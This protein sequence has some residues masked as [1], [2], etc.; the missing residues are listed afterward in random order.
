MTVP[1]KSKMLGWSCVRC[2]F[3]SGSLA[4]PL[5]LD[6]PFLPRKP[7]NK[8]MGKLVADL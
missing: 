1:C 8:M 5:I 6:F 7:R 4:V 3:Q 2:Y